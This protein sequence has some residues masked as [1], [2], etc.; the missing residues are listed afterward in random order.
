MAFPAFL[1]ALPA[2]FFY[3]ILFDHLVD[4]PVSDDYDALLRFLN[5]M[6]Q[7]KGAA[8][9][10]STFLG[11]QHNEY[12]LF[13]GNAVTW[14][15]F[16]LLGHVN[17]AQLCVLGDSAVL[18][19]AF[20]LWSIFLPNE[21]DLARRL[22]LF[23]PV[24]WLL[25]QLEYWETLN[26]AMAA[27]QNLWVIVF[28][29]GAILCLQRTTRKAYAGALILYA[30][31]IGAS[32]EGFVLLP[33]GLLIL[34][35]QRQF[36][37]VV[38]WLAVSAVCIA[39]YAYHYNPMSSQARPHSSVFATL[40]YMRPDYAVVFAGNAGAITPGLAA[41]VEICLAL[42]TVIVLLFGW[43]AWRGYIRRNPLVSYCVLFLLLT[44]VGVAGMRSDLGLTQG[45]SSR[46]T[47]YGALML[48]FAWTAVV[49]EFLQRRGRPLLSDNWY[50][51]LAMLAIAFSLCT[52]E[53]GYLRLAGR[54]RADVK[55]MAAFEHPATPDSTEG[56]EPSSAHEDVM[57]GIRS[58][59]TLIDSIRLG[60]YEPPKY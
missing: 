57:V 49:E 7:A 53:I 52:D 54:E 58:R 18:V 26:Y 34:A 55:A 11:D 56:P 51:A 19:L 42:G 59:A 22:A 20:L 6:V 13:F 16:S 48:I 21:K 14:A 40:L 31:A 25:F 39:A 29:L 38:G 44:A 1:I 36:L 28:W 2:T 17:F 50:L 33:V 30:L 12:K 23:V 8:A 5:E 15:Q 9:K 24:A 37:R 27:L 4:L 41:S 32:G 47:I 3:G 10:F 60:V 45:L 46:Y 35:M 43:L